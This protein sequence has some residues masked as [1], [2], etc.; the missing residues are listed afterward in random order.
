MSQEF[1]EI[2]VNGEILEFPSSMSD[3]EIKAVIEQKPLLQD[4]AE[5]TLKTGKDIGRVV[6]SGATLGLAP[7]IQGAVAGTSVGIQNLAGVDTGGLTAR[8]AFIDAENMARQEL[9]ESRKNLP[10]YAEL[11]A[12]IAGAGITGAG[13]MKMV[14][15]VSPTVGKVADFASRG[16]PQKLL[17]SAGIAGTSGGIYTA[18]GAE[19][20]ATERVAEGLRS[21]PIYSALGP[22]GV[23][24]AA[25][26]GA[27][28]RPLTEKAKK[29]LGRMAKP[30]GVVDDVVDAV[31]EPRA[32]SQ[33]AESQSTVRN[34]LDDIPMGTS[35]KL[36]K[37]I[38]KDFPEDAA[39]ALAAVQRTPGASILEL[40]SP[41]VRKLAQGAG[42]YR[43][44]GAV[45]GDF[46]ESRISEGRKNITNSIRENIFALDSFDDSLGAIVSEGRKKAAPFYKEAYEFN[47]QPSQRLAQLMQR[48]SGKRAMA[49]GQRIA[50]DEGVDLANEGT[51]VAYDYAKRGLDS[52]VEGARDSVTGRLNLSDPRVRAVN[53][54]RAEFVDELKNVNPAYA[55]ALKESG[56]YLSSSAAMQ[57]GIKFDKLDPEVLSKKLS[58]MTAPEKDAYRIGVSKRVRDI[59][60]KTRDTSNPYNAIVGNSEKKK[61]LQAILS[62]KQYDNFMSTMNAEKRIFQMRNQI[63]G[64]SRTAENAIAA[65]DVAQLDTEIVDVASGGKA[66]MVKAAAGFVKRRFDGINEEGSRKVA[67]L[68]TETDPIIK[69]R[70]LN[71]LANTKALNKKQSSLVKKAYFQMQEGIDEAI[72]SGK[73]NELLGAASAPIA[74]EQIDKSLEEM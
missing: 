27:V 58:N 37:A 9:S 26:A 66:A 7:T 29:I 49:Y 12:E 18:A 43:E 42:Q 34:V 72:T 60:E 53:N 61:R 28:A 64:G 69:V 10:W 22:V 35:Y 13:A 62:P 73:L 45:L 32:L 51:F 15:G 57:D 65:A 25:G 6:S 68:L 56:D 71:S 14:P 48:P 33:I 54:L 24:G 30:S 5:Q 8:Q 1:Q 20:S 38:S 2:E 74:V 63:L 39:E 21:A 67:Q 55:R 3:D 59:V 11:P 23:L 46:F 16:L 17:A 31:V 70:I 41:R 44:G 50:Q 19:G 47:F 40:S 4:V 52:M 36:G